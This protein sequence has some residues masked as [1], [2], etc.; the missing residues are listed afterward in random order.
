V[1]AAQGHKVEGGMSTSRR[2][3]A[4]SQA[5]GRQ[6]AMTQPPSSLPPP[7]PSSV[8]QAG[9]VVYSRAGR[10]RAG[11]Q[12]NN[13]RPGAREHG[14]ARLSLINP[15]GWRGGAQ[16]SRCARK[17]DGH[18]ARQGEGGSGAA[19]GTTTPGI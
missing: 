5:E 7:P 14:G 17:A 4:P 18:K 19:G 3:V 13:E 6:A 2:G 1:E 15:P 16:V 12:G 8:R 10:R 9:I 11:Q